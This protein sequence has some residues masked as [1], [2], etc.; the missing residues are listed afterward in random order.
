ME[1]TPE[2]ELM[3]EAD[4]VR[5]YA[6]ADFEAPHGQLIEL[7]LARLA[8]SESGHAIDLGCGPADIA[9]RLARALPGW[10]VDA[11]DGSAP[12]LEA[13]RRRVASE[14]LADRVRLFECRLPAASLPQ[15]GYD[16]VLSNSLLHHL[17]EPGGLWRTARAATREG[18]A[19]FVMDL[20]RPA[21]PAHA[22]EL[23]ALHAAG[24]PDVLRRD[25]RAS[26]LAAWRPEEVRAQ[27]A[28]AGLASLHV[29][30]ASDR[31][32]IAWGSPS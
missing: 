16:L 19:I 13:A 3:L 10:R 24:E 25:F 20:L 32:W 26:L 14:G 29:E 27:L 11:V 4:Q 28:D 6:E 9:V 5:A 30:T 7:L 2:P 31:H 17:S 22:D 1:R 12:M 15:P 8:P 18:G 21:S 23:V